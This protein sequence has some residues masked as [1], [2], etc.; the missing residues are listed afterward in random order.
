MFTDD[1]YPHIDQLEAHFAHTRNIETGQLIARAHRARSLAFW[2]GLVRA[3]RWLG[4]TGARVKT[5]Y[6]GAL[7]RST[8]EAPRPV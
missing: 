2:D 4:A 7:N 5:A 8:C 3:R 6:Y 1:L